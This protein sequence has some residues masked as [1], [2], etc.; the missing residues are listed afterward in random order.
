M[1]EEVSNCT[2]S[3]LI[4]VLFSFII[5]PIII[6]TTLQTNNKVIKTFISL[7]YL[8]EH[9]TFSFGRF[10]SITIVT[11]FHFLDQ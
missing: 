11:V 10:A 2:L 3:H 8:L 7:L 6:I 1:E 5:S 4:S 9:F